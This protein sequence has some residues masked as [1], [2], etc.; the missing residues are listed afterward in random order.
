MS[1]WTVQDVDGPTTLVLTDAYDVDDCELVFQ[2]ALN[3]IGRKLAFNTSGCEPIIEV[4]VGSDAPEVAI[5]ANDAT[6]PSK[7]VCVTATLNKAPCPLSTPSGHQVCLNGTMLSSWARGGAPGKP[8][9]F[10]SR[11]AWRTI[12]ACCSS[13]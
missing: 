12:S 8:W 13:P 2:G 4:N 9:P 1:L 5:Y 7:L 6:E 11:K 10:R 3:A